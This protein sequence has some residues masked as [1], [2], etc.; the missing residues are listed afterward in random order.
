MKRINNQSEFNKGNRL[1]LERKLVRQE[2]LSSLNHVMNFVV[3]VERNILLADVI[4][5]YVITV[6]KENLFD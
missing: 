4:T 2:E 1:T 6:S 3:F 5:V